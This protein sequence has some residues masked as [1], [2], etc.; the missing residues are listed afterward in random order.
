MIEYGR[1]VLKTMDIYSVRILQC[2][3][4]KI[5]SILNILNIPYLNRTR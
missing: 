3:I 4:S 2:K 5:N 1:L